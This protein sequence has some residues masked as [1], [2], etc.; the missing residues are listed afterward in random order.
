MPGNQ[1][2]KLEK[3]KGLSP[4]VLVLD[5]E[6]SVPPAEKE[7]GRAVV[8]E[9]LPAMVAP[10]RRLF[11]RV[12]PLSSGL[13]E[14]DIA[15]IVGPG[16]DGISLPKVNSPAD[17]AK[18]DGLIASA[19]R[20]RGLA[21]GG[22]KLIPWIETARS[23]LHAEEIARASARVIGMAFGADDFALD[24][25][26]V[27]SE[28]GRELLLPRG[29]LAIAARAAGVAA[30]DGVYANFKHEDGLLGEARIARQRGFAGKF[31]IHPAQVKPANR[32]F[33][34]SAQEVERAGKI[35]A[36]FDE[37]VAKGVAVAVVDGE[38]VDTPVAEQARKLLELAE[39][40]E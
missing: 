23:I 3:A 25:G 17:I 4:D 26:I 5:L 13:T 10:P 19:E 34:P 7:K 39:S 6:D 16:L 37:A 33:A 30:L 9:W 20:A 11:V 40:L 31:L 38:M 8:Q 12:N 21:P 28:D 2:S 22:V 1:P 27:R 15:A 29:L 32:I 24:M 36:A 35:V 18:A 14:A